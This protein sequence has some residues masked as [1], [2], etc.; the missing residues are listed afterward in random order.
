MEGQ[1][2]Y[3]VFNCA[4]WKGLG[5]FNVILVYHIMLI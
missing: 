4:S 1:S 5:K 3:K 2:V